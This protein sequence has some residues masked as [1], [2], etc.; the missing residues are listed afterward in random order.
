M[1]CDAAINYQQITVFLFRRGLKNSA[2]TG[3]EHTVEKLCFL[4]KNG[5]KCSLL[6]PYFQIK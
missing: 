5:D 3:I 1:N 4:I 6:I 2:Q